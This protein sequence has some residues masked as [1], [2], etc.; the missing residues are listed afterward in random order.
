MDH[1]EIKEE[2]THQELLAMNG[3]YKKLYQIQFATEKAG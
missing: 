2:G 1:G 3:F